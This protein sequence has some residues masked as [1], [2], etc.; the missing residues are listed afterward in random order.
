MSTGKFFVVK[1]ICYENFV[2]LIARCGVQYGKNILSF[3]YFPTYASQTILKHEKRRKSLNKIIKS[4]S[5]VQKCLQHGTV[6]YQITKLHKKIPIG[7]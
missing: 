3:T 1:L 7:N 2:Q 6:R 5:L 4:L